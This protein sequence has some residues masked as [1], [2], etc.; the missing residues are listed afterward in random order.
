M[1][2]TMKTTVAM[3]LAVPM[4][5]GSVSAL[6]EGGKYHG[7]GHDG[8]CGG[9]RAEHGVMQSLD[10]TDA[11]KEQMRSLRESHKAEMRDNMAQGRKAMKANHDKMQALLLADNF[12][13]NAVRE[14]AKQMSD[15]QIE[16]RVS[17][18]KQRHDM[19]N[20]LTPEQ[21]AQYKTLKAEKQAECMAKWKEKRS[22]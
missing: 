8:D 9:P 11:Q 10:L 15:Q 18:M 20:I 16:H 12:D 5:L 6:A 22:E 19:L 13:E 4:L 3:V 1:T 17:M 2:R 14:L 7:K 21:K